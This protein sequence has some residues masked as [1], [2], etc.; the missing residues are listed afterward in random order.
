MKILTGLLVTLM[1]LGLMAGCQ[2]TTKEVT[3]KEVS[4]GSMTLGI[5][6]EWQR[7]DNIEELEEDAKSNMGPEMEQY[8]QVDGYEVP[9]S[10]DLAFLLMLLEMSKIIESEGMT[11]EDWT[12][13][14]EAEGMTEEDFIPIILGAFISAG[15]QEVT[16][17]QILQHT[18]YGCEA[19]EAQITHKEEGEP[20]I[21]NL[22]LV[23]AKNDLGVVVM[24]GEES[25]CEKYEDTWHE[26]RDSVQ[27]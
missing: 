17:Q 12:S 10:E 1:L 4:V 16:Q 21:V 9:Q 11:W 23:F 7:R 3:Y 18:I 2:Q 14:L 20:W 5:P 22:L 27:F 24:L 6:T 8:I 13:L 26:I 19:V 25:A 15:A